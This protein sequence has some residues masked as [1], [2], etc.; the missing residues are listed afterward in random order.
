MTGEAL[1]SWTILVPTIGERAALFTRLM[2]AL[3]PQT[4]RYDGRIRV[5]GW[6]NNGVPSLPEIRQRMIDTASTD[7]L[8]FI[9]D[10][11][12]VPEYFADEAVKAL[13]GRPDYVGWQVQCYSDDVPTA[14]SYHSLKNG[15]W[16]N[17]PG[18]YFRD[19]SHI[20]P[21]KT[22]LARK[23]SFRRTRPGGAEDRNWADDLRR[24]KVLKTEVTVD[25]IMYH[26]L[27]STNRT[28]GLGSRWERPRDIFTGA[29][30]PET[31]HPNFAW[32]DPS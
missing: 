24:A 16:R 9:D 26:Y 15:P 3:L 25:R 30:R 19:I 14:I 2:T 18:R 1:P 20:N 6:F 7:Y 31:T 11:D 4:Q 29:D 5:A 23:G 21:I 28:P 8:S 13:A 22:P 32:M 27:Y 12:L 10:D 17:T